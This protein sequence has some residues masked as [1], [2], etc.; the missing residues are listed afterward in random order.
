MNVAGGPGWWNA[1]IR[2]HEPPHRFPGPGRGRPAPVIAVNHRFSAPPNL[3]LPARDRGVSVVIAGSTVAPLRPLSARPEYG[4]TE[5]GGATSGV[6]TAAAFGVPGSAARNIPNS[7]AYTRTGSAGA[8]RATNYSGA[9]HSSCAGYPASSASHS[10]SSGGGGHA[11]S[12]GG[13]GGGG[14]VGGGASTHK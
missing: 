3:V 4:R 14:G 12:S 8:G 7:N 11:T 10:S 6:R 9:S 1:P 5:T 13:G 2:P